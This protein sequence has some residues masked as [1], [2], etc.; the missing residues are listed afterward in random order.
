MLE[1]ESVP[2]T[3]VGGE[4]CPVCWMRLTTA[5]RPIRRSPGSGVRFRLVSRGEPRLDQALD[6]FA[7]WSVAVDRADDSG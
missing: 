5:A 3:Q 4:T 2:V 6:I 7:E 1:A